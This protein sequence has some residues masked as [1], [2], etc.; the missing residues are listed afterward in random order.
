MN[1]SSLSICCC[2]LIICFD[3]FIL[4]F[5]LLVVIPWN[6]YHSFFRVL[7]VVI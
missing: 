6:L 4:V 5:V 1:A 2:Q 7:F 3:W